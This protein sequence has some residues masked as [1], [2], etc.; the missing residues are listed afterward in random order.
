MKNDLVS[1]IV[2]VYNVEEILERCV[3]SILKQSYKNIELILVDDGSHDKCPE[4]CDEYKRQDKRVRVIHKENGGQATAR[5]AGIKIAKGKYVCFVDSDDYVAKDYVKKLYSVISKSNLDFV[6]CNYKRIY[7]DKV[8]ECKINKFNI[9][10]FI[11]PAPWNK[12][13]KKEVFNEIKFPEGVYYE[14]LGIFPMIYCK[15]PNY[16]IIED[17]LYFYVQNPNSTM[18]KKNDKIFDIY[19]IFE[20][21]YKFISKNNK[22]LL[23]NLEMAYIFHGIIG[24]SYRAAK[25]KG[26][27]YKK[28]KEIKEHVNKLF[29]KWKKNKDINHLSFVYKIYLNLYYY[30]DLLIFI[31]LKLFARFVKLYK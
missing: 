6:A 21:D 14:D 28:F 19:K 31:L 26:F 17:S 27:T 15:Y 2:P 22:K 18:Y 5:N 29:P 4:M 23:P 16:K 30:C 12:I 1:I 25:C 11:T 13:F 20:N 7:N 8:Q 3:E 9:D 24:T 10:N